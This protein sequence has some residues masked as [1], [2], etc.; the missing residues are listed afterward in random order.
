MSG[1]KTDIS[2]VIVNYNVKEHITNLLHSVRQAKKGL[3]LQIIVI[4]NASSDGSQD[5]IQRHF[6]EV[7]YVRNEENLGF[8]KAN[9]QGIARAKGTY[10]LLLN[11]DTLLE[12]DT[13]VTLK[14]Y[15]DE[16]PQTGLSGCKILNP[17]GS[18][19]YDGRRSMPTLLSTFWKITGLTSL[20][21]KNRVFGQYYMGWLDEN[22]RSQVP[23]I[24]GA[25]MFWRTDLLQ[26]LGGFDE[27]YF[28][29]FEDTDLCYRVNHETDYVIEYIPDTYIIHFKGESTDKSNSSY[30][31]HFNRSL[32]Q[33]FNKHY[34]KRYT[35][36]MRIFIVL[37]IG[38]RTVLSFAA[39]K[40]NVFK[41]I[42]LDLLAINIIL[43]GLFTW[44]YDLGI[45]ALSEGLI[46]KYASINLLTTVLYV[47]FS[48]RVGLVKK[49][50]NSISA[51]LKALLGSFTGVVFITFFIRQWAFSRLVLTIGTALS[52][53]VI[54]AMRLWR[55][56][57]RSA[58]RQAA[59]KFTV[60]RIL[61]VGISDQTYE[62]INRLRSRVDWDYE[63]V[64][65][66]GRESTYGSPPQ[67]ID[68]IPVLGSF[69]Q[70]P[71]L[72]KEYR[73]D[74]LFFMLNSVSYKKVLLLLTEM[75]DYS[76]EAKLIP[77]NMDFMLGK[78][79]VDYLDDIP[80]LDIDLLYQSGWNTFLKRALDI[81]VSALI[82]LFLTPILFWPVLRKRERTKPIYFLKGKHQYGSFKLFEPI[83]ENW[84]KNFYLLSYH[85][86]RGN[87]SLIGAPL[88]TIPM[89]RSYEYRNGITGLAQ[90]NRNRIYAEE[91]IERFDLHY[92]Q[93]Y[94]IWMDIDIL[95]KSLTK[96]PHPLVYEPDESNQMSNSGKM[97]SIL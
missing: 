65:V 36:L 56:N 82:L 5:F 44:R 86:L 77:D 64:G 85:V 55:K 95:I 57:R 68:Q 38:V 43:L 16:H 50:S 17:D 80:L 69:D 35:W 10:T 72:A 3:N 11:P 88:T 15:M 63:I 22:E 93:N 18:Y 39:G 41:N 78:S 27:R 91:D 34:S 84:W 51:S 14:R 12:E 79:Q 21:P 23:V 19:S 76:I 7:S 97:E 20:F 94:T 13:L 92:L 62:L 60:T 71:K 61:I 4:D 25:F 26:Q 49:F 42:I 66:V 37:G 33:F 53:V 2:I 96:S 90:V 54:T 24:S 1:A 75:R 59:G 87:I 9:N 8:G 28:M 58:I 6:P 74:Q 46:W 67:K 81:V 83:K 32:Y 52:M 70:I 48:Y 73:I 45:E 40:F 29:Y 31:K 89:K 47:I 30:V